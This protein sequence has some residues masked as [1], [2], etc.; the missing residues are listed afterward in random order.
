MGEPFLNIDNVKET[1]DIVERE[2][3]KKAHHYVS[4]IGINDSDFSFVKDN[5]T[6]QLS[7]HSL[8]EDA[9]NRLIPYR[10]KLTIEELGQIRTKSDL[11]TTINMTLVDFSDFDIAKL[12]KSFDPKYFFIKLSPINLN[13]ISEENDLGGGIIKQ[14][15]II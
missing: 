13:E 9:R 14:V 11:K 1:I 10:K 8:D 5:I 2:I 12:R 6:L 7:L 3:C 15:N 4:T